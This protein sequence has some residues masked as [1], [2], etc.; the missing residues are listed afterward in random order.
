MFIL[1]V[2]S[3]FAGIYIMYLGVKDIEYKIR[4]RCHWWFDAGIAAF[5][6]IA[7]ARKKCIK[8]SGVVVDAESDGIVIT[9]PEELLKPFVDA[10]YEKLVSYWWNVS[11]DKQI[12]SKEVV[13][14]DRDK[15]AL[16]CVPR[17]KPTPVAALSVAGG[18]SWRADG[19]DWL[20]LS[21]VMKKRVGAFCEEN[22]KELWGSKKKLVYEQPVCHSKIETFPVRGKKQTCSVC[23]REM[24]CCD[25]NQTAFPL[26]SSKS[27]ALTFNPGL[28]NPDLICWECDML[29]KFAVHAAHYKVNDASKQ[30]MQITSANLKSLIKAHEIIGLSGTI[31]I[32]DPN[33]L[34]YRNFGK[35]KTILE[36][37]MLPYEVMWGFYLASYEA[38]LNN[39]IERSNDSDISSCYDF[40]EDLLE[41]ASA[42]GIVMMSLE[43]KGKTF[44][45]KDLINFNDSSY[46][47]RLI[48]YIKDSAAKTDEFKRETHKFFDLMFIDFNFIQNQ[49]KKYDPMNGMYRNQIFQN[50]FAK[51]SILSNV[52]QFVFKK[53]LI[54]E[55]PYLGRILFLTKL[56]ECAINSRDTESEGGRGMTK[57]QV[58]IAAK[59]GSQLVISA[60]KILM[61]DVKDKDKLKALK[62][63]LFSLR[64]TRTAVDFLEQI[65]RFQFRYGIVVNSDICKGILEDESVKFEDFKAY[66]MISALNSYNMEMRSSSKSDSPE[67][68]T[69]Q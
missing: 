53:S 2:F 49:Q 67:E 25:V 34:Y 3:K 20:S 28:G 26:F 27:A 46:I 68:I 66:C 56:Y 7:R 61:D 65:N 1:G 24:V 63:S 36:W 22:K 16:L 5:Y 43:D 50:I 12:E 40:E 10:C 55:Y 69:G 62:G 19:L 57:E 48:K 23:G 8:W 32:F 37:A 30:I 29:G 21:D 15:D 14:Y 60:K 47:F 13:L 9:A 33:T 64:K 42:I 35:K 11:S 51:R 38:I 45:T 4:F 18:S 41:Y 6:Y 59:L 39:Q 44:I 58:E 52:E 17:R 54:E 31:R